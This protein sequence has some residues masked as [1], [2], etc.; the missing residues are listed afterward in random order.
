MERHRECAI[1][2]EALAA[3]EDV[4]ACAACD[5]RLHAACL[6]RWRRGSCPFCRCELRARL[7]ACEALVVA[8]LVGVALAAAWR[9]AEG[10]PPAQGALPHRGS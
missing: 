2:L 8:A 9:G 3:G 4:W 6:A 10:A 5:N 7:T 1:C